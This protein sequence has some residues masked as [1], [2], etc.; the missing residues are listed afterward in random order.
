MFLLWS[1]LFLLCWPVATAATLLYPVIWITTRPLKAVGITPASMLRWV[2][3]AMALPF[4]FL[5]FVLGGPLL[6]T[7]A[8]R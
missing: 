7:T 5:R 3:A 4:R 6:L 2:E 1:L 8:G